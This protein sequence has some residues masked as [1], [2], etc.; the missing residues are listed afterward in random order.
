MVQ[1]ASQQPQRSKWVLAGAFAAVVAVVAAG[2]FAIVNLTGN[3][4]PGG[5][6]DPEDLG[7]QMLAAIENED[8]LGAID[9]L[10][11]GER[12]A[13]GEPFVELIGELQRIELLADTDLSNL[14]GI[15]VTL[16]GERVN[17]R[18]TN[19]TDIYNI[20]MG[21]EVVVAVDGAALPIG[22]L[23]TDS[24][25]SEMLDELRGTQATEA[26][27]FDIWLTA[28][29]HDGRWYFSLLHSIAELARRDGAPGLGVPTQGIAA[30]G[31]DTPEAAVDLLFQHVEQLDLGGLIA[32]LNPDEASA[33]QRYS[34]LFLDDAESALAEVPLSW[35]ITERALRIDGGGDE[36]TAFID[37]LTI[38]GTIDGVAFNLGFS[39]GCIRASAEGETFEQCNQDAGLD[40]VG[41]LFPEDSEV[42][43]LL[44]TIQDAFADAE[45]A[46][47]ELRLHDGEWFVSP[48]ATMTEAMLNFLRALDRTEIDAIVDAF[49]PAA[50]ELGGAVFGGLE[51][52]SVGDGFLDGGSLDETITIEPSDPAAEAADALDDDVAFDDDP[53]W[54]ACYDE[55]ETEAAL[56]CFTG[57]V[58]SGEISEDVVPVELRFP[59]CGYAELRWSNEV[60][61]LDDDEFIAA[62]AP[63][64]ECFLQ[65]VESGQVS[66]FELPN[67]L[68]YLECFEGRNWY[69]VFDDPDYDERYYACIDQ[70]VDG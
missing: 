67:E 51:E 55:V 54:Y 21:A 19:V 58:T 13:L 59:E 30:V 41:E 20:D 26:D 18:Q 36:R 3:S 44:E 70:R 9:L 52:L 2:I 7:V 56:G 15:D 24:M 29:E 14:N 34:P 47:L 61:G 66:L 43:A 50:D 65:L 69:R 28:V 11:P 38:D 46:G 6:P 5:A 48:M 27:S 25:P 8:M 45:E 12:R 16:S 53:A 40:D 4:A 10:L 22:D 33:L 31:A 60:Y 17:A 63:A 49:E 32:V 68:A 57:F 64:S 42:V 35:Q 39:D 23:L 1:P 37:A 62:V